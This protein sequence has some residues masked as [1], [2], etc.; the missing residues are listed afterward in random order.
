[1]REEFEMTRISGMLALLLFVCSSTLLAGEWVGWLADG[2]CAANGAKA[3]HKGC[4]IKCVESGQP[5]V[6]VTDDKKVFKFDSQEKV[7]SLLGDRVTLS[8]SI[9]GDTI[10]VASVKKA[11]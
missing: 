9:D 3:E 10:K 11:Q 7:K 5:I 8:G 4:S 6:F 1:M 2:K